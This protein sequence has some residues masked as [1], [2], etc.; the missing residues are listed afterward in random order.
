MSIVIFHSEVNTVKSA[1]SGILLEQLQINYHIHSSTIIPC[2][3][4]GKFL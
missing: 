3:I 1:N 2:S 4:P